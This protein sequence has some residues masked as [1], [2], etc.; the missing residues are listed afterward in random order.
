MLRV[1]LTGGMGAGKS[2]ASTALADLG[3]TI[4]DSD[5]IAREV[6]APGTP[7]LAALVEAF[8]PEILAG[9]GSLDR[10]ALAGR[11]F[12]DD[13]SRAT[14]NAITHPRVGERTAELL[15]AAAPDAIVVQDIPLLVENQLAPLFHLVIVVGADESTRVHRLVTHRGVDE[16]DARSRIAT[17]ATDEQRRAVADV[18]LD[19][20]GPPGSLSP[21]ITALWAERLVPYERNV[22]TAT[23][24]PSSAEPVSA[25]PEW[26]AQAQRL[27]GRLR[28]ACGA[29]AQRIEHVGPTAQRVAAPDLLEL[30]VTVA[31]DDAVRSLT[32]P[33][34]AAGFPPADGTGR[35]H[36]SADPGRPATVELR[37][38]VNA[39]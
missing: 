13:E 33:L 6:V 8:G 31:D 25:N 21:V 22:R 29:S 19:N 18:W 2:T 36:G 1:G 5:R 35:R 15:A 34:T 39:S 20:S 32:E 17:Q 12:R 3:A 23:A 28:L 11:A 9:D 30:V 24:A 16:A 4:V 7:G 10:A 37:V 38:S 14:L 27:I 26:P